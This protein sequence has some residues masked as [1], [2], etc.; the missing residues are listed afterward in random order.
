MGGGGDSLS[1][2]AISPD[3]MTL[4]FSNDA[5]EL[6]RRDLRSGAS[7]V[8]NGL[9]ADDLAF[10]PDSRILASAEGSDGLSFWRRGNTKPEPPFGTDVTSLAFSR[11]GSTIATGGDAD[12]GRV[13]LWD[14]ATGKQL[15]PAVRRDGHVVWAVAVSPDG[16]TIASGG[17]GKVVSLWPVDRS[18][19]KPRLVAANAPLLE[20]G[21]TI[22]SIEFSPTGDLVAS[23]AFDGSIKI[24]NY[25]RASMVA[26]IE[27]DKSGVNDI[28]FSDDGK[29]IA[30]ALRNGSVALVDVASTRL[31]AEPMPAYEDEAT[32]VAFLPDDA[33]LLSIGAGQLLRWRPVWAPNVDALRERLCAIVSRNLTAQEWAG[34]LDGKRHRTCERWPS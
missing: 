16:S 25:R 28:A 10:S 5:N 20:H 2:L 23:A 8:S 7:A 13:R 34:F 12:S 22:S 4:A 29:T 33:A 32:E 30:A 18:G 1:E 14:V 9:Y 3:G 27:V 11:D 31:L 17:F 21:D 24:W 15:G 19:Q 6:V 26:D